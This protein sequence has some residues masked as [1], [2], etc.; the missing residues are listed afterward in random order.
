MH[1]M[2]GPGGTTFLARLVR[3]AFFGMAPF[4]LAA[5]AWGQ[6]ADT[7]ARLVGVE[8]GGLSS[9]AVEMAAGSGGLS[10]GSRYSFGRYYD[11]DMRDLR[12]TMLS[13]LDDNFGIIWG[14]GT[15]EAGD[16]YHIEPSLKIGF[17]TT[18]RISENEMMSFSISTVLWG[19]FREG[20]CQ[21]DYGAIGGV[22]RVNCRMADSVLAP[23]E[24][25]D[26][27][28]NQAPADQISVS[29]RYNLRF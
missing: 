25:L 18:E 11:T 21:A 7:D 16:K 22:Q 1:E 14:F 3:V 2:K 23:S 24:T 17:V 5:S 13:Q 8:V 19:Y 20:A 15:G 6:S 10:D 28:V 26:Y 27:L 9:L 29:L 12:V 4:V